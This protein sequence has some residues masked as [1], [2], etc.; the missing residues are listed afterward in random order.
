MRPISAAKDS[1]MF[2]VVRFGHCLPL[3]IRLPQE[4]SP[5]AGAF[6]NLTRQLVNVGE[7]LIHHKNLLA[8]K[9]AS[10]VPDSLVDYQI[11]VVVQ[12]D[13]HVAGWVPLGP[14]ERSPRSQLSNPL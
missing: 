3:E 2:M 6:A 1:E 4:R 5:D 14:D 10:P 7:I 8:Q 9:L 11:V 13:G 12:G